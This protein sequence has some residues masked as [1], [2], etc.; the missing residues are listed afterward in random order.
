MYAATP[1]NTTNFI[2]SIH[3]NEREFACSLNNLIS[4][5]NNA[6]HPPCKR[7]KNGKS[8]KVTHLYLAQNLSNTNHV[9]WITPTIHFQSL[10]TPFHHSC[11]SVCWM[12]IFAIK[13][14]T[15]KYNWFQWKYWT[16][17]SFQIFLF[18]VNVHCPKW[19]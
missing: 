9:Y 8:D 12:K 4:L 3:W 5:I 19:I 2:H 7:K 6:H 14:L 11:I 10:E 13:F 16:E 15:L 1:M 18:S 17:W